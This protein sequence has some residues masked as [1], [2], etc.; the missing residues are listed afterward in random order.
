MFT[1]AEIST[2][3]PSVKERLEKVRDALQNGDDTKVPLK[4]PTTL[5]GGKTRC[6]QYE[7]SA[8]KVLGVAEALLK[9]AEG[10][11]ARDDFS[12]GVL[13][14]P[15]FSRTIDDLHF[16]TASDALGREAKSSE[17]AR[18]PLGAEEVVELMSTRML[19]RANA[20]GSL[21]SYVVHYLTDDVLTFLA[22]GWEVEGAAQH[23][24]D[25]QSML[26]LFITEAKLQEYVDQLF[27]MTGNIRDTKTRAAMIGIRTRAQER[28]QRWK[29]SEEEYDMVDFERDSGVQAL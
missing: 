13:K 8:G 2:R 23:M 17:G 27:R 5:D 12:V 26:D 15:D 20:T 19:N 25:L 3:L 24:D 21:P 7:T 11:V 9:V 28:L 16:R 18:H 14:P 22:T 1:A 4:G 6:T 10:E 29:T